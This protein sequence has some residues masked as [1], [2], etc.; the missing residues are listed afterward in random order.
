MHFNSPLSCVAN[1]VS[2]K[3]LRQPKQKAFDVQIDSSETSVE[4]T[5]VGSAIV[6]ASNRAS[7]HR[8]INIGYRIALNRKHHLGIVRIN[9]IRFAILLP[10]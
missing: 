8:P 3:D 2:T 1:N 4:A 5:F 7:R 9:R 6:S 10:F